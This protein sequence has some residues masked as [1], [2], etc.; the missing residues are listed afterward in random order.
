MSLTALKPVTYAM[1]HFLVAVAVAFVLTGSWA[2][3]FSI[4]LIEPLVQTVAY[5]LHEKAWTNRL[6][7]KAA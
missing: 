3:A 7:M 1:I 2:L 5:V 4:G 6:P